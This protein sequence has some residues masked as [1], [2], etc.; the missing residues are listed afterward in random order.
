MT[1]VIEGAIILYAI[2]ILYHLVSGL[3][4]LWQHPHSSVQKAQEGALPSDLDRLDVVEL[5]HA[6]EPITRHV[7]D[8]DYALFEELFGGIPLVR[9]ELELYAYTCIHNRTVYDV[10]MSGL[11]LSTLRKGRS[12]WATGLVRSAAT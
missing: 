8:I 10:P 11:E 1:Y 6:Q 7:E 9:K 2:N 4:G 5:T 12:A 3:V